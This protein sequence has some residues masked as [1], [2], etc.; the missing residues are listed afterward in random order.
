GVLVNYGDVDCL[1]EKIIYLLNNQ[2]RREELRREAL[3]RVA[4]VYNWDR[5]MQ[6]NMNELFALT[7]EQTKTSGDNNL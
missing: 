3:E 1:A 4:T 6:S 5:I 7:E 2:I